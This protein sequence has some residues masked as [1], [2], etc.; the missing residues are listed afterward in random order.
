MGKNN[1]KHGK[2]TE[3]AKLESIMTK[4]DN[5]LKAYAASRKRDGKKVSSNER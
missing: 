5:K 2:K 3:Y 4:L 1:G